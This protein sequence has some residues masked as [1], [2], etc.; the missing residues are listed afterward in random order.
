M[1]RSRSVEVDALKI[2]RCGIATLEYA[3][4][5]AALLLALLSLQA[6]L[7]RALCAKWRDAADS[8]GS[9]RQYNPDSPKATTVTVF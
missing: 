6:P 4:F 8:F 2:N 5:I 7:R 1:R 3:V 9:G